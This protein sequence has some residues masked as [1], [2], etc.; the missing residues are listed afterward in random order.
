VSCL[1]FLF[2]LAVAGFAGRGVSDWL[3]ER[4]LRHLDERER[5]WREGQ[6]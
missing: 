6:P 2:L 4:E 5:A 3:Y 1:E